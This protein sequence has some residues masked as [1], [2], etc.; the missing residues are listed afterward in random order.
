[1]NPIINWRRNLAALWV[2]EFTAIFGFSF[3]FPFLPAFLHRDLGIQDQRS[4]AFWTGVAAGATGFAMA[5]ASP[6]WG[7]L[8]DRYGRKPMLLRAML[9]AGVTVGLMGLAQTALQLTGLRFILGAV[10]GTVPAATAIVGSQSPRTE[11]AWSLG[12]L[13]SAIALGSAVG[14][15]VGGLAGSVFGLRTVFICGGVLLL[16]STIPVVLVVREAPLR[17]AQ[18]GTAPPLQVL[19]AAGPGTIGAL[20]VLIGGQALFQSSYTA[21]QQLVALRIVQLDPAAA[22]TVIGITFGIGGI[23]TALAGV[24][25]SRAVRLAGYRN[26][27]SAA[28]LLVAAITATAAVAPS[29]LFIV[30]SL[31]AV[32]FLAG[33]LFPAMASMIGLE[34]PA[35]IH[36]TIYG[37]SGSAVSIGFGVGPLM[38]GLV[39][40]SAG[41]RSG[42]FLAAA[43]ALVLAGIMR[44]RA[45]EPAP[46]T[47]R[48]EVEPP[49]RK[50]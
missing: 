26:V 47:M 32:S 48:S 8:A 33:A 38:G 28:A 45:R 42:L 35:R 11:V 41:V 25:Y 36:A 46:A 5:F 18:D 12:I 6:V 44:F 1:M 30:A 4:L 22:S 2:A 3:A 21:I 31:V 40:A 34:T 7:L 14:P 17:R 49:R 9:G 27:T 20:A 19:R 15:A 43:I 37:V 16:V 10:S 50:M 29:L 13:S 23:G 39:A 24:S